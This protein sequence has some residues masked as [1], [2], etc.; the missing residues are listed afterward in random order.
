MYIFRQM[1]G[2]LLKSIEANSTVLKK[3]L[4][5]N[6]VTTNNNNKISFVYLNILL[7]YI[8]ITFLNI[9]N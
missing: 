9:F 3:Q 2:Y 8:F 7:N 5:Y 1:H 4:K 6:W